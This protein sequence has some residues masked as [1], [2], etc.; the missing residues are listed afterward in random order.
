MK[1]FFQLLC[2]GLLTIMILSI[3]RSK[4]PLLPEISAEPPVTLSTILTK[5]PVSK[6]WGFPVG[7]PDAKGYYN[8]Q[9]FGKNNHLGDDWNGNGG[10]NSDLGDDVF[11]ISEGVVHFAEDAGG[12]W[13]NIV[14]VYHNVGSESKPRYIESFYAHLDEILVKEGD[15][16]KS[17]Q[18]I[19]TIG[20]VDGRYLAHLHFEIRH[21]IE[22]PIGPGYSEDNSGYLDPT[23][24]IRSKID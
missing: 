10:G 5:C 22:L 19:G 15:V 21:N 16:V 18:K 23:R 12:G 1:L 8:A 20:N 11:A 3:A 7:Y 14:R 6:D 17:G 13:G 2:A 4:E 24:F 9:G